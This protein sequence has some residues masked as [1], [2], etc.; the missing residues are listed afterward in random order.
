LNAERVKYHVDIALHL[1]DFT[2]ARLSP[3]FLMEPLMD[4]TSKKFPAATLDLGRPV[5]Q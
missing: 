1:R 2:A 4:A 5:P 3:D